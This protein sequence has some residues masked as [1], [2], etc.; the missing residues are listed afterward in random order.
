[1]ASN[2]ITQEML[3]S[4][5]G[6]FNNVETE[7]VGAELHCTLENDKYILFEIN[8]R[9]IGNTGA[10]MLFNNVCRDLINV[11]TNIIFNLKKCPY[12]SSFFIGS[13]MQLVIEHR[14]KGLTVYFCNTNEIINDLIHISNISSMLKVTKTVDDAVASIISD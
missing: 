1:M 14:K 3:D 8:G 7:S 4:I 2:M 11:E 10:E 13:I 6:K 9:V 5:V 12:L